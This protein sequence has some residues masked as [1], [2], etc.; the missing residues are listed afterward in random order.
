[1]GKGRRR[2][3][4]Q[5]IDKQEREARAGVDQRNRNVMEEA[6]VR[7]RRGQ[8]RVCLLSLGAVIRCTSVRSVIASNYAPS[9]ESRKTKMKEE[10]EEIEDR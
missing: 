3:R 6:E 4:N 2:G 9:C 5:D 1:V 7:G 8:E 10:E